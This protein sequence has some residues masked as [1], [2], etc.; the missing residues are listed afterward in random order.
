MPLAP[1]FSIAQ[2]PTTPSIV[3]AADTSTGSDAAIVSRR[4]YF[5]DAD[6]NYIVPTETTTNYIVWALANASQS[7][8]ILT[9]DKSLQITV[10][11]IN[12]SG[13]VLYSLSQL[14]CLSIYSKQFLYYLVQLQGIAPPIIADANY[15]SNLALVWSNILGAINAVSLA[16]DLKASQNCLDRINNMIQN[17]GNYF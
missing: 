6:G 14:F 15:S 3:V 13:S 16:S 12:V 10:E 1:N 7:F 4:I 9:R 8:D 2:N 5:I 11:W 17:K